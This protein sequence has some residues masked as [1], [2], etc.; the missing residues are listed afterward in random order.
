MKKNSLTSATSGPWTRILNAEEASDLAAEGW[1]RADLHVHTLHSCDVIPTRMVHPLALYHKA[2]RLGMTY[3]SFTDH[4]SMDAYDQIG[5]TREGLVPAVEIKIL[6]HKR[7][8]HTVHVNVY[9]LDRRQFWEISKIARVARDIE[10]LVAYLKDERL[11]F[12]FNHP[13]WHEPGEK[14][15]LQAVLELAELFP[16]LEYNMGRIGQL[17]GAALQL[18]HAK[19]KGVIATTDTHIGDIG[20]AFTL[21]RGGTFREFFE[22]IQT[23]QAFIYPADLTISHLKEETSIR[24]RNLFDKAGWLFPKETFAMDTGS[25]VLDTIISRLAKAR[26]GELQFTGKI[27]K[28]VLQAISGSG[29]P[30]T[31]YLHTQRNLADRIGKVLESAET[32]A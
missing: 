12:I 3:V 27:F 13:F 18:A 5:W 10:R 19:R 17:N 25:A 24:I 7:I 8:G 32:T 14:P 28:R 1:A 6:D 20:R 16:V 31:F 2:R 23:G 15:N 26:P 21:A 30:G 9:A 22:Q 29:I 4:D 11:P